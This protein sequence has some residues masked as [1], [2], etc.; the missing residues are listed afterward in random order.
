MPAIHVQTEDQTHN[1][2]VHMTVLNQLSHSGWAVLF[3]FLNNIPKEQYAT[4]CLTFSLVNGNLDYFSFCFL[5]LW[6]ILLRIL[7]QKSLGRP[8]FSHSVEKIWVGLLIA[9]KSVCSTAWKL[10]L[11]NVFLIVFP[12]SL[13]ELW[14]LHI[15]TKT[16]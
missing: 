2:S 10:L 4:I 3:F 12:L 14:L 16:E 5:K 15:L 13:Y 7:T 1:L 9:I 6:I 11:D 8:I